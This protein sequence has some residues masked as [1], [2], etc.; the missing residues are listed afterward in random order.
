M[1][2]WKVRSMMILSALVLA[3]CVSTRPNAVGTR[4]PNNAE[5]ICEQ[6]AGITD[7]Y[8]DCGN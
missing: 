2:L 8:R 5:L 4:Q 3:S 6:V 7:A 1:S